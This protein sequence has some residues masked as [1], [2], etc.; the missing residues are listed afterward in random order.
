MNKTEQVGRWVINK[1]EVLSEGRGRGG[2]SQFAPLWKQMEVG[3]DTVLL[4]ETERASLYNMVGK[5]GGKMRCRTRDEN[6]KAYPSGKVM[7]MKTQ[8]CSDTKWFA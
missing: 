1:G 6:G 3:R 2:R 5:H 7:V 8:E 4:T